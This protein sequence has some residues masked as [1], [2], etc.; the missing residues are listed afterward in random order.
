MFVSCDCTL[1]SWPIISVLEDSEVA[2][3]VI[4]SHSSRT[5]SKGWMA[6]SYLVKKPGEN[7]YTQECDDKY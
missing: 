6:Q 5:S 1:D 7:M 3:E 2:I 4:T